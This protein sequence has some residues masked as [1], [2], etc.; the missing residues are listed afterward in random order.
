MG[1][2]LVYLI[3]VVVVVIVLLDCCLASV[4]I[5]DE[6]CQ[7]RIDSAPQHT[8]ARPAPS[9]VE[10]FILDPAPICCPEFI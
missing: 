8:S 1:K 10:L 5:F 9:G 2:C 7:A 4:V 6:T 3:V